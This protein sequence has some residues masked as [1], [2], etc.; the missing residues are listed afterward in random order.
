MVFF[1]TVSSC[2]ID[3]LDSLISCF[4]AAYSTEAAEPADEFAVFFAAL[5][6]S[7][8][9]GL[10]AAALGGLKSSVSSLSAPW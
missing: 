7:L 9:I 2:R 1:A 4:L 5:A 10:L 8:P 6:E 3:N